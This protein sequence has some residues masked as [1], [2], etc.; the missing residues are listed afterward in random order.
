VTLLDES[1]HHVGAHPSKTYHAKLHIN[2][3]SANSFL[4]GEF[5]LIVTRQRLS[6]EFR[7]FQQTPDT[8]EQFRRLRHFALFFPHAN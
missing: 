5:F 1:P 3:L 7:K 8:G 4:P 6:R 2:L